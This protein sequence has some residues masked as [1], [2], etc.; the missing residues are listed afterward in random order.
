MTNL[1]NLAQRARRLRG[2]A[3]RFQRQTG[4]DQ[5]TGLRH[6]LNELTALVEDLLVELRRQQPP[7]PPARLLDR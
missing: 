6:H 3:Q 1:D 7:E 5:T 4:T 2:D